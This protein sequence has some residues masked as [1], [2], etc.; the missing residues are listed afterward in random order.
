MIK[1]LFFFLFLSVIF[2]SA[3][4]KKNTVDEMNF[5]KTALLV[6]VSEK[7][8]LPRYIDLQNEI[9]YLIADWET[10][11]NQPNAGTLDAVKT[12]WLNA[13]IRFQRVKMFNFGPA[14]NH[15]LKASFGTFPSDTA[16]IISNVSTVNP[17]LFALSNIDAIGFP[18]LEY[19][20]YRNDALNSLTTQQ[21]L[22]NYVDAILIKMKSEIDLV[23]NEWNTSYT[24]IFPNSTGTESTSGFSLLIN[25]FNQDFEL[26]KNAKLGIPIG[27]Q[28]LGIP[29]LE[30]EEAPFSKKSVLLLKENLIAL[31]HLYDGTGQDGV[32]GVG[33][34]DYL[35]ALEKNNVQAQITD[36]FNFSF[37]K[38]GF[39]SDDLALEV[40][41][42]PA[43]LDELYV[44]MQAMV[45]YLKTD[46]TSAFGVLITYQDNDGD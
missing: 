5:N 4:K 3:C 8:A 6:Q 45:V 32:N 15:G 46:M 12:K 22:K 21:D 2:F 16:K 24:N 44:N 10:F 13:N 28:S 1:K 34:D 38:L 18:A 7:I 30:Y 17:D 37:V 27:K 39:L 14:L 43:D 41:S 42:N 11:K 36:R 20:F 26:A 33:F 23:V 31:R 19:L 35:L 40:A 25:A 29:Q 9:N